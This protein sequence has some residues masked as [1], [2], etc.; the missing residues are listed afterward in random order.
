MS[1][2]KVIIFSRLFS[3]TT[4]KTCKINIQSRFPDLHNSL[5]YALVMHRTAVN[6]FLIFL[7]FS[8]RKQYQRLHFCTHRGLLASIFLKHHFISSSNLD[9][10]QEPSKRRKKFG[11]NSTLR[12]LS[13]AKTRRIPKHLKGC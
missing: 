3:N 1:L 11:R 2:A 13:T 5:L 10:N 6:N 7:P 8:K 12:K 4:K 9:P